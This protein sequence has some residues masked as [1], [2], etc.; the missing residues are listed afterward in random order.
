M[1]MN[2]DKSA[3]REAVLDEAVATSGEKRGREEEDAEGS[4]PADR[5][6]KRTKS[7]NPNIFFEQRANSS[8]YEG[9]RE[10]SFLFDFA[11]TRLAEVETD[12][13]NTKLT[14]SEFVRRIDLAVEF[15]SLCMDVVKEMR[16]CVHKT[17]K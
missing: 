8:K 3:D 11:Y 17:E 10:L 15:Q 12:A 5:V 6:V 1:S 16:K 14:T 4:D 13:R 7:D 9:P 2:V